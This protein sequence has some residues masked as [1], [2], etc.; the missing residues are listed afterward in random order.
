MAARSPGFEYEGAQANQGTCFT[1]WIH[2][3]TWYSYFIT[4]GG[5][6]ERKA[7]AA[8]ATWEMK[9]YTLHFGQYMSSCQLDNTYCCWLI[10]EKRIWRAAAGVQQ[11]V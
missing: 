6:E 10:V 8:E 9:V 7:G 3:L 5:E 11:N 2:R 4:A 1:G